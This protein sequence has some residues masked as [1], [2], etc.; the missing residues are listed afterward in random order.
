[1][2]ASMRQRPSQDATSESSV[3]VSGREIKC[4]GKNVR[5]VYISSIF[6]A[7]M[8]LIREVRRDIGH[9]K[10]KKTRRRRRQH[11]R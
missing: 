9:Q 7:L 4:I 10:Y 5:G 6:K 1:M 11:R 8:W 2:N 3:K